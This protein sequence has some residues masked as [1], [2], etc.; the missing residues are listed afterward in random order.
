MLKIMI[1]NVTFRA[2]AHDNKICITNIFV[3]NLT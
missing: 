2:L 3:I 1:A